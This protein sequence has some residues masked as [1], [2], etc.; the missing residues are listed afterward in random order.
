VISILN[1]MR[2]PVN[3]TMVIVDNL[4]MRIVTQKHIR[5]SVRPEQRL[6]AA[7]DFF[8]TIYFKISKIR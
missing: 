8:R 4:A 2:F 1:G 5:E 7:F 3:A 6:I